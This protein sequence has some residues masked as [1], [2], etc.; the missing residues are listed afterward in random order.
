MCKA[1]RYVQADHTASALYIHR[2]LTAAEY[3]KRYYLFTRLHGVTCSTTKLPVHRPKLMVRVT[4][5]VPLLLLVLILKQSHECSDIGNQKLDLE[6]YIKRMRELKQQNETFHG[7]CKVSI[8][9]YLY[10][11]YM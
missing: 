7:E 8:F 3:L 2:A 6:T 11:K 1:V 4:F 10:N 9:I 5:W